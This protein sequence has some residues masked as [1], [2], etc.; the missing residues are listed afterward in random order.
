MINL[1]LESALDRKPIST[2]IVCKDKKYKTGTR[3][4]IECKY[5]FPIESAEYDISEE[6]KKN[7]LNLLKTNPKEAI[8]LM[9]E[10]QLKGEQILSYTKGSSYLLP[11]RFQ[12]FYNEAI[13]FETEQSEIYFADKSIIR[14]SDL[15]EKL[16]KR[17]EE[18][19]VKFAICKIESQKARHLAISVGGSTYHYSKHVF[20][21]DDRDRLSIGPKDA[22][23]YSN[24]MELSESDLLS[25]DKLITVFTQ[26]Y[27]LFEY[28]KWNKEECVAYN[29]NSL[30][31]SGIDKNPELLE[32][33]LTY[34]KGGI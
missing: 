6:E 20:L 34:K 31:I 14:F 18:D 19:M 17:N 13:S 33:V 28:I 16:K 11:N 29:R 1:K 27:G 7:I 5:S 23:Y 9:I 15:I 10:A 12:R 25:I 30:R 21:D 22:L 8:K 24:N 2:F 4:L 26:T 32:K 3:G